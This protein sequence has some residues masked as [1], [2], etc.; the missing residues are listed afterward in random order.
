MVVNEDDGSQD[1]LGDPATIASKLAPTGDY[2]VH[3]GNLHFSNVS[4]RNK[5]FVQRGSDAKTARTG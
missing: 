2:T 3:R 5:S 4:S 1:E